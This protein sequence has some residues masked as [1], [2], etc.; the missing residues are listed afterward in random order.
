V[1]WKRNSW[2]HCIIVLAKTGKLHFFC[3]QLMWLKNC[4]MSGIILLPCLCLIWPT[5]FLVLSYYALNSLYYFILYYYCMQ[6]QAKCNFCK[7]RPILWWSEIGFSWIT[8]VIVNRSGGN[9]TQLR[10]LRWDA[11]MVTLGVVGRERPKWPKNEPFYIS[12]HQFTILTINKI[13]TGLVSFYIV[14]WKCKQ[15]RRIVVP[16]GGIKH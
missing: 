5:L 1:I 14:L 11:S 8:P 12:M 2:K 7:H 16:S 10:L 6:K 3:D 4:W 9:F 13:Y 15:F